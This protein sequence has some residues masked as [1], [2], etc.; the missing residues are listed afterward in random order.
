MGDFYYILSDAIFGPGQLF[1]C[2]TFPGE[3]FRIIHI[4]D[5]LVHFPQNIQ[6]RTQLEQMNTEITAY[7]F[8]QDYKTFN[9]LGMSY[10]KYMDRIIVNL[11]ENQDKISNHTMDKVSPRDNGVVSNTVNSFNR[12]VRNDHISLHT[13]SFPQFFETYDDPQQYTTFYSF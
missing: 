11:I 9:Y 4:Q 2:D 7:N 8:N 13:D 10:E 5:M 12:N 1:H 6:K 3:F